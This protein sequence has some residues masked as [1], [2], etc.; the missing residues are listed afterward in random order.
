MFHISAELLQLGTLNDY[1]KIVKFCHRLH[2]LAFDSQDQRL[3]LL[4]VEMNAM[5][6]ADICLVSAHTWSHG[7][8]MH[9][10]VWVITLSTRSTDQQE[11]LI[12]AY[13]WSG[14]ILAVLASG[15]CSRLPYE[16]CQPFTLPGL[17]KQ[18]DVSV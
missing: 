5:W 9:T 4:T 7:K 11:T 17:N 6:W 3:A 10:A 16:P 8:R 18:F 12:Y 14:S 13:P 1:R 15:K 2:R